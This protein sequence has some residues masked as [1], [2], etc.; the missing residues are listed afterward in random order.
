[1]KQIL[2]LNPSCIKIYFRSTPKQTLVRN[3][4]YQ[5]FKNFAEQAQTIQSSNNVSPQ[6]I[7]ISRGF[8]SQNIPFDL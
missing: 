7:V 5:Q 2:R 3:L 1:M 6:N 4:F 8:L